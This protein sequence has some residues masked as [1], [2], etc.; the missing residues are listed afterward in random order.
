MTETTP[1]K[2]VPWQLIII[3]LVTVVPIVAAYLAFYTG[4]G[5]PQRT[6]NEGILLEKARNVEGLFGHADGDLPNLEDNSHWRLLVPVPP[7]C[8]QACQKNL[9]V[10]R[11]VHIRLADKASRVE[12]YAVNLAGSEGEQYL[13]EI[14][15]DHPR[16]KYFTVPWG[17]WSDWLEGS[18][19]PTDLNEEPYYLLID[20]TGF[21]MMYYTSQHEG[22]QLLKD[23]KRVL[24][25]SPE[26]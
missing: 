8:S 13:A 17:V 14:A 3:V 24:R 5:V 9:Y 25:F 1:K 2:P 16:L 22:N 10:T 4:V 26:E 12:R 6:V 15:P 21:A 19:V 7:D 23:L 20:Q 18:G 11:Q